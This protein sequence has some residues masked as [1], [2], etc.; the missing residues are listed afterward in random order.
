MGIRAITLWR[1]RDTAILFL[2]KP[3]ENREWPPPPSII[4]ERIALH[5]GKKFDDDGACTV[6]KL[7]IA[8]GIPA[9]VVQV[10]LERSERVESAIIG[11]VRIARVLRRD[12]PQ[13]AADP[14]AA[15][16]WFFGSFGWVCEEPIAFDEPIPCRGA[17]GLWHV[18]SE[19]AARVL[20]HEQRK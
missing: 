19:I 20:K 4:G 15:S 9:E 8:S 1:P 3:V 5:S 14:L 2:G 11:T 12:H 18:P 7:A 6:V 16:P 17:Q 13:L 10:L